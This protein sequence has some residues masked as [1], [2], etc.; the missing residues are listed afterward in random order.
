LPTDLRTTS[1]NPVFG[2][3]AAQRYRDEYYRQAIN[4]LVDQER[5]A[6]QQRGNADSTFGATAISNLQAQGANQAFFSGED[7]RNQLI[8]QTLARRDSLFGN[9]ARIAQQQNQLDVDRGLGV[10]GIN[11]SRLGM[12]NQFQLGS[13][14]ILGNMYDNKAKIEAEAERAKAAA[15]ASLVGGLFGLGG[16]LANTFMGGRRSSTP[17]GIS[18]GSNP[19]MPSSLGAFGS[20][21]PSFTRPLSIA[22]AGGGFRF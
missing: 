20:L 14:G 13:A 11:T 16:G 12:L 22:S 10:E 8:N 4:P 17:T 21:D 18:G 15:R 9:E 5:M 1:D 7:Y 6:Q 19:T 3:D 2:Q